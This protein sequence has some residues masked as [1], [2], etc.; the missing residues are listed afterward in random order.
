MWSAALKAGTY[1][2]SRHKCMVM[3]YMWPECGFGIIEE[4]EGDGYE[5]GVN[6]NN[7]Q[8]LSDQMAPWRMALA[9]KPDDLI[10]ITG[11]HVEEG[12]DSLLNVVLRNPHVCCIMCTHHHHHR[13]VNKQGKKYH[14][15]PSVCEHNLTVCS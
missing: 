8:D 11:C 5:G 14:N 10:L 7:T 13:H 2:H 12:E 4:E 3:E 9:T 6:M 1:I 15:A